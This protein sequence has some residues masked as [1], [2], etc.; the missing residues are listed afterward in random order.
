LEVYSQ[1]LVRLE[2]RDARRRLAGQA[3]YHV[4]VAI[5]GTVAQA[6]FARADAVDVYRRRYRHLLA[7]GRPDVIAYAVAER[8]DRT[9]FWVDGG[10]MYLWERG[11]LGRKQTAA[12]AEAA[13]NDAVFTSSDGLVAIHA[14][15]VSDG[16]GAAAIIGAST[17]GKST[18]AIACA[19]RGLALH[20]DEVCIVTSA[21]VIPF[22]RCLSLR[23]DGMEVL[24]RDLAPPS[25]LDDWLRVHRGADRENVG[26]D[27]IFGELLPAAA[28]PLRAAF[29]VKARAAVAGARPITA[30]EMLARMS[31]WT[32]MKPRGVDWVRTLLELLK[33][34]DCYELTLGSP[35][36]TA[37]LV[38]RALGSRAD[39]S[40]GCE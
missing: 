13:L 30:R 36:A 9:Y 7:N 25:V 24:A 16:S 29:I 19:R 11:P 22:P 20:S 37:Q 8:S 23:R 33:E 4:S 40:Q 34:V 2:E 38:A 31:P 17:A 21:G 18:T 15:V 10:A 3:A 6:R 27:E 14:A 1:D 32:R 5:A 39:R 26:F 28:Q 35:D 12:L